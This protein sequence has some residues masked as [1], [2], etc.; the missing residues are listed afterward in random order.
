M[1]GPPAHA[2]STYKNRNN[3]AFTPIVWTETYFTTAV[4]SEHPS[5]QSALLHEEVVELRRV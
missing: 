1:S 3:Q 2:D 4:G 5:V